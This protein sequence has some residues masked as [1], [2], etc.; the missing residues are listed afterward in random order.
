MRF[1]NEALNSMSAEEILGLQETRLRRQLRYCYDRSEFYRR[2]FAAAGTHPDEIKTLAEFRALP[3]FMTKRD[4]RLSQQESLERF[5]HPFG[6]HL[7]VGLD[8]IELTSTTSG[9]TGTPTFTYTFSRRELNGP[10]A[11]LW[12]FMFRYAGVKPGDRVLF[13]Y[14]LGVY[15]TSMLLWGIRRLGAIPIDVDVRGG[16]DAILQFA[17]LTRPVAAALTPSLAEYLIHRAPQSIGREVGSLGL[18]SVLLCGEPGAGIPEVKRRLE[19]A[20]R[21]RV[22][23]FWAPGGLGFGLACDAD[24]YHG[25]HCYAPDYNLYQDDLIDPSTQ[26]PIE[27]VDGAVGEAVHTSLDR[28]ASPVIRYAYGDI[29]QVFTGECPACGFRGKRLKFV[30]RSD[31]ML[32]VKGTNFY[33]AALRDLVSRFI[34]R[35]TGE[36]RVVLEVEPPR[37]IPPLKVKLEYG[38]GVEPRELPDLAREVVGECRHRLKVSPEIIWVPPGTFERSLRKTSLVE[39]AYA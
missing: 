34:P 30:G 26:K 5:G 6:M 13:G 19:S 11:D 23:D 7:C 12:A 8:E 33:P 17:E 3:I 35:V 9:T 39:R 27:V 28:D 22:Y 20:Y 25:L 10:V 1:A 31:D 16:A 2:K 24:E 38:A 32:I 36:L 37:V 21:A 4:E 18:G 29:V 14:A 15:A